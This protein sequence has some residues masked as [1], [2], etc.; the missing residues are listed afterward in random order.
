MPF[1]PKLVIFDLDGTLVEYGHDFMFEQA[2]RILKEMGLHHMTRADFEEHFYHDTLFDFF[3][4]HRGEKEEEFWG[5]LKTTDKP[6]SPLIEGVAPVF[7]ELLSRGIKLAIATARAQDLKHLKEELSGLGLDKWI[8]IVVARSDPTSNWRDKRKQ[9]LLCC[10]H[11]LASPKDSF[12]VGDN[13]SD[14]RSAHGVKIGGVIAV[15]TGRIKDH[16]LQRERPHLILDHAGLLGSVIP[17]K[18]R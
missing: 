3:G 1:Q 13:P 15:R 8:D 18:K 4:E 6:P 11:A 16:V 2:E 7:D 17:E 14:I 10:A 12:M 9:I 5:K